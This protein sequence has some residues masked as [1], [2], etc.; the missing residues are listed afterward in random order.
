MRYIKFALL[1]LLLTVSTAHASLREKELKSISLKE[2]LSIGTPDDDTL[3]M[4]G[5]L[6]TDRNGNI[7]VTDTMDYS[8][9]KFNNKGILIKKAGGMGQGPGEF[10]AIRLIVHSNGVVY[11]TDQN[12]LGLHVF[13][14]DLNFKEKIP[15][16]SQIVDFKIKNNNRITILSP[17]IANPERIIT[18]DLK[19]DSKIGM[20]PFKD[21]KE[22]WSNFRK[23]DMDDQGNLYLVYSFED[24][25][26]KFDK[27]MNNKWSIR[28]L[29]KKKVKFEKTKSAFGS[30]ILPT[31]VMYKDIA[32]DTSGR[33]FVLGG[34]LSKHRSRDVFVLDKSGKHLT[35]FVLPDHTHCIHIDNNNFLYSSAEDATSLKK[36]AL[37]YEYH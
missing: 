6:A 36:Y 13:D 35:T 2:V 10:L 26:E 7:Y 15:F 30:S 20:Q 28:L 5:A 1:V 21:E 34:H 17:F 9:K 23:F 19:G 12:N 18:I 32:L 14:E 24:R 33:L 22:F 25:V 29:G 11:V 31:E 8:I 3:Y 37:K 4:W 27:N 16:N